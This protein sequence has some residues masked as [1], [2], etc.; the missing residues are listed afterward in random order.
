MDNKYKLLTL[1]IIFFLISLISYSQE[2]KI[3]KKLRKRYNKNI[4]KDYIPEFQ[5]DSMPIDYASMGLKGTLVLENKDTIKGIIRY[6][7]EY[8][9]VRLTNE[10]KKLDK[11]YYIFKIAYFYYYY[12]KPDSIEYNYMVPIKYYENNLYKAD[13][14]RIIRDG[15][16]KIF[17]RE[18]VE[19]PDM[20]YDEAL[21]F[22]YYYYDPEREGIRKLTNFYIHLYPLMK[23]RKT[24][25]DN[26]IK[27]NNLKPKKYLEDIFNIVDYYN[28]IVKY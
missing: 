25:I 27:D 21:V 1:N 15:N 12:E 5:T 9:L 20:M 10:E 23:D 11:F 28:L 24:Q 17:R 18:E 16:I 7:N 14:F 26:Y 13:F 8:D 4:V 6:N 3:E 2:T 22:Y 19:F